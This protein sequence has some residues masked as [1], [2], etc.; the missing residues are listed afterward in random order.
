MVVALPRRFAL[1]ELLVD[2][3]FDSGVVVFGLPFEVGNEE[4]IVP[5]VVV[6]LDV[7]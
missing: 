1:F 7:R 3:G 4:H 5:H 6:D 2:E